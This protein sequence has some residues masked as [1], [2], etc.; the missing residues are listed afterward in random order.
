MQSFL[1]LLI[2]WKDKRSLMF[3]AHKFEKVKQQLKK[4]YNYN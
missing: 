1:A 2:L 3:V 4:K